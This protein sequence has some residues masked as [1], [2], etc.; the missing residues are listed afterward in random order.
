MPLINCEINIILTWSENCVLTDIITRT[1]RNA[2]PNANPPV[3]A[4]ESIDIPTNT[5]FQITDT[6]FYVLVVT[7]QDDSKFLEY[8]NLKELL[9]GKNIDQK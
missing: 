5:A 8:Q 4:R 2:T 9:N 6:K 3:Q 7:T 1:T